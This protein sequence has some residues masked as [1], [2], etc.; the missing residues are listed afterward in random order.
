MSIF[1][2][3][4]RKQED[5]SLFNFAVIKGVAYWFDTEADRGI[6]CFG[7][8]TMREAQ[9]LEPT[10]PDYF[11]IAYTLALISGAVRVQPAPP[12]SP[13]HSRIGVN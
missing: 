6:R 7:R 11:Q 10:H 13:F 12:V 8:R 1:N 2:F 5:T 3:F 9:T 4:R